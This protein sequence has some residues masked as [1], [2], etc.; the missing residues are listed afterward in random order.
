MIWEEK[1][2]ELETGKK[3][4]ESLNEIWP[5]LASLMTAINIY[6]KLDVSNTTNISVL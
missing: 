5:F 2:T 6:S 4:C 3:I 1:K